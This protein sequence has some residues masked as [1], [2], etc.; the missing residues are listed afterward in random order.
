MPVK[1]LN[2]SQ[3]LTSVLPAPMEEVR[4]LPL[5]LDLQFFADDSDD[6]QDDED[7]EE[8]GDG[9]D[10]D[11]QDD[12]DL[13]ALLKSNPKAKAKHEELLKTQLDKRMKKFKG[14]DP[15]EYRRLKAERDKLDD[16]GNGNDDSD[17]SQVNE[18][19]LKAET[20]EKRA[21]AK[22][23]AI[24]E[25]IDP[26]LFVKFIN[27]KEIELD[28]DGDPVNLDELLEDLQ[29]GKYAKYFSANSS[30][31]DEQESNKKK[32]KGFVPGQTTKIPSKNKV[33]PKER[34]KALAERIYGKKEE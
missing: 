27:L 12:I 28:E 14:V 16:K 3:A 31:D 29:E 32:K 26:V 2:T 6:D 13:E 19:V 15:A 11:D 9:S 4:R 24:D 33:D 22:E 8:G 25:G 7:E 17:T 21:A 10:D 1:P 30:D 23:F 34:G 18:K 20:R 5:A